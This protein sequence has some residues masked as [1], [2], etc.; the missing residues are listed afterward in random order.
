[1]TV[2]PAKIYRTGRS[3]GWAA[4]PQKPIARFDG[5]ADSRR[6]QHLHVLGLSLIPSGDEALCIFKHLRFGRK[7]LS[8]FLLS[9]VPLFGLELAPIEPH[10]VMLDGRTVLSSSNNFDTLNCKYLDWGLGGVSVKT[11]AEYRAMAEECI[12]WAGEAYT[13]EVRESYLQLAQIW[14]E[15]ASRIDGLSEATIVADERK[16]TA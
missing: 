16:K 6:E 3:T 5:S 9:S 7:P 1:M 2:E 13:D 12:K 8:R 4:Y 11:A 15:T 14:L 10:D